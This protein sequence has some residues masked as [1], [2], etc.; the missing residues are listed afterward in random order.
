[1][2][3]KNLTKVW[4]AIRNEEVKVKAICLFDHKA[5]DELELEAG[6]FTV[7]Y[8]LLAARGRLDDYFDANIIAIH[9]EEGDPLEFSRGQKEMLEKAIESRTFFDK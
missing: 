5:S 3:I 9:N 6:G 7:Y 8:T 1:M 2:T 4:K